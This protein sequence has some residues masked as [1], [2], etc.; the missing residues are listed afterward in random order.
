MLD[1]G[2]LNL[3]I[4]VVFKDLAH[5]RRYRVEILQHLV[6]LPDCHWKARSNCAKQEVVLR[7]IMVRPW[8]LWVLIFVQD[9]IED[10][11]FVASQALFIRIAVA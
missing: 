8:I 4:V 11:G 9:Q 3:R 6:T 10:P 5:L 7:I 2:A 1:L